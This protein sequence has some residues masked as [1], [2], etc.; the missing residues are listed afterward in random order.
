MPTDPPNIHKE[1]VIN[2]VY[3]LALDQQSFEQFT[4]AWD[5]YMLTML[6]QSIDNEALN[7]SLQKHF[8]RGFKMLEKIGRTSNQLTSLEDQVQDRSTPAIVIDRTRRVLATNEAARSLFISDQEP[9]MVSMT[10]HTESLSSLEEGITQ[11]FNVDS[12]LPIMVLL[13]NKAPSLFVLQNVIGYDA[14]IIDIV[15][16]KWGEH[17]NEILIK[18]YHLTPK[19]CEITSLIYQGMAIKQ[20]AANQFRSEETVRSHIRSVF[21][22]THSNSQIQLMRL[23]TGINFSSSDHTRGDWFSD[24]IDLHRFTLKD[25]RKIDYYDQGP[26]NGKPVLVIHGILHT[27]ELPVPL[28]KALINQGYRLIGLCRPNFGHSTPTSK[29]HDGLLGSVD[30]ALQ[31]IKALGLVK[32]TLLGCMSGSIYSFAM[33]AQMPQHVEKVICIAGVVPFMTDEHLQGMSSEVRALGFTARYFPKLYPLLIRG[34]MALLDGGDIA[35]FAHFIYRK[36]PVDLAACENNVVLKQ[37]ENGYHFTCNQGSFAYTNGG[38]TIIKDNKHL[39]KNIACPI[40]M[41]HGREDMIITLESIQV[42]K[43][44][45]PLVQL[46]TVENTGQL[47]MYAQPQ[48]VAKLV[49]KHLNQAD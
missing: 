47:L 12:P 9:L 45:L 16:S 28:A 21:S 30:D 11:L 38:L 4:Q 2:A 23:I 37:L 25:G 31:I 6:E 39:V 46:E 1:D 27:P 36:S 5:R 32:V 43:K 22:K 19:E 42:F 15:G 3:D 8:E 49:L 20:I 34:G 26:R 44:E 10:V 13:R 29:T 41:I 40:I 17:T 14:I 18:T 35:R 7:S 33:A 24:A 48:K